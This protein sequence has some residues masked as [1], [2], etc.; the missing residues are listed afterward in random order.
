MARK[1]KEDDVSSIDELSREFAHETAT[2]R[3]HLE[4]LP[5][6][7]F[8]WR[9][10]QK[11]FTASELASHIVECVQFAEP[12][13][14]SGELNFDSATYRP[15]VAASVD[16]L[17]AALDAAVDKG[18]AALAG[19]SETSLGDPWQ[20]KINGRVRFERPRAAVFRDFTL[21]HVIHHRGQFSVYLRLLDVPVPGSYGP[22]ADEQG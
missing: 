5:S 21:S 15:F 9:P 4:R 7:K 6:D 10:H 22:S 12:I 14:A 11:S 19:C 8:A 1:T 17:L 3:R 2:T 18:K 20:F 16:E 13:M